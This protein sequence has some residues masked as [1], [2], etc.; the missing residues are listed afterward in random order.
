MPEE[1]FETS[2]P[3]P[4]VTESKTTNWSKVILVAALG[5]GLLLGAAYAG[6]WYGTQRTQQIGAQNPKGERFPSDIPEE[7][8]CEKDGDCGVKICGCEALNKSYIKPE[9]KIC[10]MV[11]NKTPI[12]YQNHCVFRG[13]ENTY[14]I[15]IEE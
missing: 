3:I 4:P 10:L 7:L 1:T 6:Y 15:E 12:C 14:R 9:D 11:C 13:E 5:F 2:Q 8:K